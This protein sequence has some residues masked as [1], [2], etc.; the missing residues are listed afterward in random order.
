MFIRSELDFFYLGKANAHS[1][2]P[3][4]LNSLLL[5]LSASGTFR[6]SFPVKAAIAPVA[7]ILV[8]T[9]APSG[10][11]I[12]SSQDFQVEMCLPNKVSTNHGLCN[13]CLCCGEQLSF[14]FQNEGRIH[15][16]FMKCSD[17]MLTEDW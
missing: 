16:G 13:L 10:E 3:C 6:L 14:D 9:I 8:Y 4:I 11:V 12:A 1:G 15:N 5:S 7:Q 17:L 2:T